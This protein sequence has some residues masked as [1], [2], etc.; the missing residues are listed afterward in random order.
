MYS[1]GNSSLRLGLRPLSPKTG[2][3]L[4]TIASGW[5]HPVYTVTPGIPGD[6]GS[7]FLD[8]DGNALGVL[9]TL[10]IAPLAGSN[11]V[12][13]IGLALEYMR[14]PHELARRPRT[15]HRA[16]HGHRLASWAQSSSASVERDGDHGGRALRGPVAVSP[17]GA[18]RSS[19]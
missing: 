6:S 19:R 13:D 2:V 5:S 11:N 12:S 16:V 1:Y 3:S 4:G 14:G 9:S 17:S 18:R 8:A 7:A 10:A 15:G